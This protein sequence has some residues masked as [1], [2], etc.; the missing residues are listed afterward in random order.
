VLSFSGS[1]LD[2]F[3]ILRRRL[4]PGVGVRVMGGTYLRVL[5]TETILRLLRE[6]WS[7]A[8]LPHV[9]LHPYDILDGYEQWSCFAELAELPLPSRCYWWA[10]QHQW[11]TIG[12][13]SALRKLAT[14]YTE[15]KHTGPIASLQSVAEV[16]VPASAARVRSH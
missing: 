10:R 14:I 8:Y 15:F 6:A 4:A 1:Q 11:H 3:P 7:A 2:E 5:P 9:Y 13:R 16:R 12:N